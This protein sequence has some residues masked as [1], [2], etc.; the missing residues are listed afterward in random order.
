MFLYSF[1][2]TFENEGYKLI[3]R[4]N[5]GMCHEQYVLEDE[6]HRAVIGDEYHEGVQTITMVIK[7]RLGGKDETKR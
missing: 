3:D 6:R 1:I 4:I 5:I 7:N 2:N